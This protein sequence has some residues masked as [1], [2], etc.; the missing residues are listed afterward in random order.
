MPTSKSTAAVPTAATRTPMASP[1]LVLAFVSAAAFALSGSFA[2][3]LFDAGW[4]P[5]AAVAIRIGG[6]AAVLLI[7]VI[8]TL[9]R[10]WHAVKGSL[11]RI[12][13]YGIVPIA[14]CQLFSSTPWRIFRWAWPCC[15]STFPRCCWWAGHGS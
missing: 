14:L 6:A 15:W 7:P 8:I 5:G 10:H 2:K 11:L 4:S 3:S 9:V 1:A 13:V 12:A